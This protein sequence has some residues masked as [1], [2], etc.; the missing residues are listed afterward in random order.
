MRLL[1]IRGVF[2]PISDSW[3]LAGELRSE[4][5]AGRRV[6]DLCTGSGMLAVTAA[7]EGASQVV[8]VDVSRRALVSV[9]L[10]AAVNGVRVDVRRGNLFDAVVGMRFDVIV[11]NPP[12]VPGPADR[13]GRRGPGR[14]WEAGPRGRLFID[15]ICAGAPFHLNPGGAVLLVQSTICGEQETLEALHRGGLQTDVV[16][17]HVGPLGPRMRERAGWLRQMG[18]LSDDRDEVIVVR[19]RA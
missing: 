9:R 15:R 7:L 1:P 17:R 2:Q 8:A 14:A 18:V 13:L 10:N 19:G 6:L 11:S 4:L 12:Y 16:F 3:M 5:P